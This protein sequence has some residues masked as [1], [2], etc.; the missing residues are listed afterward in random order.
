M[1]TVGLLLTPALALQRPS[2]PRYSEF[3]LGRKLYFP[4]TLYLGLRALFRR[5]YAGHSGIREVFFF[6]V[7]QVFFFFFVF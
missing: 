7:F 4:I 6:L 5:E 2:A 1:A 3:L